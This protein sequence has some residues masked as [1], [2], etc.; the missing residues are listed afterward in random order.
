MTGG[1]GFIG[2]NFVHYTLSHHPEF[3]ITI[4]DALTYAGNKSNLEAV[5]DKINFVEGSICD[6]ELVDRLVRD[7]DIVVHFAA[8]SH[9]DKSLT[10]PWPFV[11]TNILGT[12]CL[13][14]AVRKYNRRYHHVSTDEVF[15]DLPLDDPM[16]V[17]NESSPYRPSSPYAASKASSDLLVG[18]WIRSFGVK[19]TISNC[20]N[21]YGPY[22]HVEKFIPNIITSVLTNQLPKLRG[23]G[24]DIR[25]WI[26]VDDHSSAV[27]YILEHGVIG[28]AYAVGATQE[29][30]SKDVMQIVLELMGKPNDWYTGIAFRP[31]HDMRYALDTTKLRALGWQPIHTDLREGLME[32]IAWYVAHSQWWKMQR[33]EIDGLHMKEIHVTKISNAPISRKRALKSLK[34]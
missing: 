23:T 21:N 9:N 2:S 7:N 32:T 19:G 6:K 1:A 25:D 24:L 16:K 11:E 26:H 20:T 10:S 5:V 34:V 22:Q 18:A 8:E 14:E 30:T 13:L 31:G 17:F 28:E 27:H 33:Q 3:T 12:C 29:R 4:L 15:G